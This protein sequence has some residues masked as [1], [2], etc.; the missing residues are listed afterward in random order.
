M[1]LLGR[2]DHGKS[3][4]LTNSVMYRFNFYITNISSVGKMLTFTNYEDTIQR[5]IHQT[6]EKG[7]LWTFRKGKQIEKL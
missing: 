2:L 7:I 1:K 3:A 5:G 6:T 4:I